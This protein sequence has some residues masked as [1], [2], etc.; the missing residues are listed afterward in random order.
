MQQMERN[1][2]FILEIG[3]LL[4]G[5]SNYFEKIF[6]NDKYVCQILISLWKYSLKKVM[7]YSDGN[8]IQLINI[9][10]AIML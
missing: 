4:V 2:E 1:V 9:K 5:F 10:I 7:K 3:G 8:D 6:W